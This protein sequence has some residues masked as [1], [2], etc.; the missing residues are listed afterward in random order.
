M[1]RQREL[2]ATGSLLHTTPSGRSWRGGS[3]EKKTPSSSPML[4]NPIANRK[5]LARGA[6]NPLY[7]IINV[8]CKALLY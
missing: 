5:H 3:W 8:R 7:F 2:A 4:R 1:E 6:F